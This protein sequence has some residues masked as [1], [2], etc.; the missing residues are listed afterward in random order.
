MPKPVPLLA[1]KAAISDD[2]TP[3]VDEHPKVHC[4]GS[5]GPWP[6]PQLYF[7]VSLLG[8]KSYRAVLAPAGWDGAL[9]AFP[10]ATACTASAIDAGCV[11]LA[12]D[13][14]GGSG[15]ETLML[16]PGASADWI[17]VVDSW[18]DL[19]RGPFSLTVEEVVAAGNAL[20]SSPQA[21]SLSG[22]PGKVSTTGDTTGAPNEHGIKI[23]C[24]SGYSFD[25]G[26]R[27][28]KAA[29]SAGKVYQ[30]TVAPVGWDASIYAF[31]TSVGCKPG[32]VDGA[33]S[34]YWSEGGGAGAAESI[35][36]R[37]TTDEEWTI[38]VDSWDPTVHGAFSLAI[39]EVTPPPNASC[40]S[41]EGVSLTAGKV[42]LT[43][44]TSF[45]PDELGASIKCGSAYLAFVGH[46]LQ[47]GPR[48][49]ALRARPRL[50]HQDV[51]HRKPEPG[52]LGELSHNAPVDANHGGLDEPRAWVKIAH[53]RR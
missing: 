7:K 43:G 8:S 15:I 20:C 23:G 45:A 6:G 13:S 49:A 50:Q 36:L 37:P 11:D 53:R 31:A 51:R 9:Y 26:Q 34:G 38:A 14:P 22:S 41:A 40:G 47:R 3:A 19:E 2:T 44:D 1:G 39:M 30:A 33:C 12:S 52:P 16:T 5:A 27:Y 29:L 24:N 4:G 10:A 42:T 18:R 46:L 21:L 32:I 35:L 28:F 25:A 48:D 17:L